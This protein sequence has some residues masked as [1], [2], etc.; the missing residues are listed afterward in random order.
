MFSFFLEIF[1][2][3]PYKSTHCKQEYNIH[4]IALRNPFINFY[5][6]SFFWEFFFI[7]VFCAMHIH[8]HIHIFSFNNPFFKRLHLQLL[9]SAIA[10]LLL[11]FNFF[12][13][14]FFANVYNCNSLSRAHM[15]LHTCSWAS[16]TLYRGEGKY[17]SV[18]VCVRV[19]YESLQ[20]HNKIPLCLSVVLQTTKYMKALWWVWESGWWTLPLRL[21][22]A[23]R[24]V[25]FSPF[26]L[27]LSVCQF[28]YVCRVH[29]IPLRTTIYCILIVGIKR[30]LLFIQ[31]SRKNFKM[32]AWQWNKI[33]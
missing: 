19:H 7:A 2:H 33:W 6:H 30:K 27:L 25:F 29:S 15:H 31:G 11:F 26:H 21:Y 8:K 3:S 18:Y 12:F 14:F 22:N 23:C 1:F 9:F 24:C 17:A 32:Q 5:S 13:F 10:L 4:V 20:T 28:M 16:N